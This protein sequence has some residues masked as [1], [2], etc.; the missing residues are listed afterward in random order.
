ML[1]LMITI[2]ILLLV[3]CSWQLNLKIK[4]SGSNSEKFSR[5]MDITLSETGSLE[6][7]PVLSDELRHSL[8]GRSL[9]RGSNPVIHNLICIA[10]FRNSI[11]SRNGNGKPSV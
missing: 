8:R 1:I 4:N 3:F 5:D 7:V 10:P 11:E 2:A 9:D 6:P